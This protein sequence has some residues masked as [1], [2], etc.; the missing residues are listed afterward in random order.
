MRQNYL[1]VVVVPAADPDEFL[2]ARL[3]LAP[4]QE[5]DVEERLPCSR[6]PWSLKPAPAPTSPGVGGCSL[7]RLLSSELPGGTG[8]GGDG[9]ISPNLPEKLH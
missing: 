4:R 8:D 3:T 9:D 7:P 6:G 2:E 1:A 5:P